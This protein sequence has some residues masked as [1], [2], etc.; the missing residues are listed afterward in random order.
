MESRF[1]EES[2]PTLVDSQ[3]ETI[4][5]IY[6]ATRN[7]SRP[8]WLGIAVNCQVRHRMP[9]RTLRPFISRYLNFEGPCV[10][11][12]IMTDTRDSYGIILW[13]ADFL[14]HPISF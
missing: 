4:N 7:C 12:T 3:T 2:T 10:F 14:K 11:F 13:F 8:Y 9:L 1:E 6:G 5:S